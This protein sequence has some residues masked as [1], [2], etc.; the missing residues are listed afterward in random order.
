[1]RIYLTL[2]PANLCDLEIIPGE[3]STV[4][5]FLEKSDYNGGY[6]SNL[7]VADYLQ[8]G[9]V[10]LTFFLLDVQQSG[11]PHL[12]PIIRPVLVREFW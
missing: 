2:I 11:H 8:P 7:L 12:R 9:N 4:I 5:F 1:M 10:E 6:K 3:F